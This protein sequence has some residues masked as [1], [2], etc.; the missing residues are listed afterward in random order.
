MATSPTVTPT[1]APAPTGYAYSGCFLDNAER[2]LNGSYT[3]DTETT[4][5]LCESY[6]TSGTG[7]DYPLFG[8]EVGNQCF[9]G[10]SFT[11]IPVPLNSSECNYGCVGD[12]SIQ[13]G[14]Y[15]AIQVYSAISGAST[16]TVTTTSIR[17]STPS[18]IPSSAATSSNSESPSPSPTSPAV[19]SLSVVAGILALVLLGLLG[20]FLRKRRS[21]TDLTPRSETRHS[22]AVNTDTISA[23]RQDRKGPIAEMG[24]S[25]DVY[26]P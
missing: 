23:T 6:C 21:S 13:C 22:Q 7:Q 9:C 3:S 24:S 8:V 25:E 4:V 11:Q 19:I 18:S 1:A 15:W 16:V 14:G 2:L 20:W 26:I 12:L 17:T 5:K 10:S